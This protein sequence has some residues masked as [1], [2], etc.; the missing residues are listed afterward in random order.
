M[1]RWW[2][3]MLSELGNLDNVTAIVLLLC[4]AMFLWFLGV[5]L[6]SASCLGGDGIYGLGRFGIYAAVEAVYFNARGL[7]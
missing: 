1:R 2:K 5:I 7:W 6:L 4:I 3:A